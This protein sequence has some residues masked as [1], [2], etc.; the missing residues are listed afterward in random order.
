MSKH[1]NECRGDTSIPTAA[2]GMDTYVFEPVRNNTNMM[3][4]ARNANGCHISEHLTII[5]AMVGD[6]NSANELVYVTG[7]AENAA[8][9]KAVS[10]E[11]F[12]Q[13]VEMIT[14]DTFFPPWTKVQPQLFKMCR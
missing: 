11:D 13:P 9:T 2:F 8:A 14:L 1:L 6:H 4:F 3:H 5:N 12:E 7:R 10:R